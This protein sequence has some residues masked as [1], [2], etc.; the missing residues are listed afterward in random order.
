MDNSTHKKE[1]FFGENHKT[2]YL[3]HIKLSESD[4]IKIGVIGLSYN[5]KNDKLFQIY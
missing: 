4:S 2:S 1:R 3:Y 5:L